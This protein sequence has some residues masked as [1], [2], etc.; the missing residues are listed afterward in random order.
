M[1]HPSTVADHDERRRTAR[2]RETRPGRQWKTLRRTRLLLLRLALIPTVVAVLFAQY[3]THDIVP[4]QVRLSRTRPAVLQIADPA[5]PQ[6]ADT[7]VFD[8]TGLGTL[9]AS[10]TARALP[11]LTHLGSVWAVRYDNSGIDTEVIS[12][13]IV[14]ASTAADIDNI[15]LVGHS[16]GGVIALEIA[17]HIYTGSHK[18]L[19][20][21]IL[22][23]TPLDLNAVRRESRD[24]AEELLRWAGWLPGARE[25]RTLRLSVEMY[26]RRTE[27]IDYSSV[28]P[29]IRTARFFSALDWVLRRKI[30][31]PDAASNDLIEAQ[32]KT[33]V[34]GG[35]ASDLRAL[36][37][38]RPGTTRPAIV[39][40]RPHN[41]ARDP[42]VD[43]TYSHDVLIDLVGGIHGTLLV[44][45]TRHTGHADPRRHPAEYNA[46]IE[47]QIVPF[48]RLVG[49]EER[50]ELAAAV[51]Q[52]PNGR[53]P[54]K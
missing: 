50:A 17:K 39:F 1:R 48:I 16:M 23:C 33:I 35:A 38:R 22:D 6:L 25:S 14:D 15:V 31:S 20:A 46:V 30:L 13:L 2:L 37:K 10:D 53:P 21:V 9:D 44:V 54:A 28:P 4:E 27:F 11:A 40:I 19:R 41:P 49:R 18:T 7:A 52:P 29:G 34:A 8:L 5:T 26:A 51:R 32:F 3:W 47:Q 45:L 43:D 12:D 36:A 42:V 24:Q